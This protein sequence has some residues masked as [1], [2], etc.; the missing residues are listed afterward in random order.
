MIE[1]FWR[2]LKLENVDLNAY[3]PEKKTC[4]NTCRH[5]DFYNAE[6]QHKVLKKASD[7]TY[8]VIDSL[9]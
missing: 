5:I 8:F 3:I 7:Q 9:L 1:P 2:N 4:V 6:R